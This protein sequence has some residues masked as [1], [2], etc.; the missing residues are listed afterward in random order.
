MNLFSFD[1]LLK[2]HLKARSNKLYRDE[3]YIFERNLYFNLENIS[4]ALN[5]NSYEFGPY[6]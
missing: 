5:D 4:K 3:I 1:N 2:A 6:S